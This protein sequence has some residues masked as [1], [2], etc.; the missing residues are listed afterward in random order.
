M[1]YSL[2]IY[3]NY[4]LN[5][6]VKDLPWM[7]GWNKNFTIK[8][9]N[10]AYCKEYVRSGGTL[11]D[12]LICKNRALIYISKN[13]FEILKRLQSIVNIFVF[14]IKKSCQSNQSPIAR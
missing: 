10:N 5:I 14:F 13:Y 4:I 2:N 3:L 6:T 12:S 9:K 7:S 11:F 8:W 1:S